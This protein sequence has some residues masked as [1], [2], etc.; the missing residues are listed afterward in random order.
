MTSPQEGKERVLR[1]WK[2]PV[3]HLKVMRIWRE[4]SW[5]A[6]V[7]IWMRS[8]GEPTGVSFHV[9]V[10]L[11]ETARAREIHGLRPDQG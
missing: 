10:M 6:L 1:R 7:N 9:G 8:E 5:Q 2:P 4:A 11:R 3:I